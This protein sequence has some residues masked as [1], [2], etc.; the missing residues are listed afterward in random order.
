VIRVVTVAV[1]MLSGCT[2][3]F[4]IEEIP[5][6]SGSA[7]DGGLDGSGSVDAKTF[8]DGH[9][10]NVTLTV[11]VAPIPTQATAIDGRI[12][13][14]AP[15]I[16]CSLT[17]PQTQC[18]ATVPWGTQVDLLAQPSG[19]SDW[20]VWNGACAGQTPNIIP[21]PGQCHL[22]LTAD[23]TARS[24]FTTD[25]TLNLS[26]TATSALGPGAYVLVSSNFPVESYGQ[27]RCPV[28]SVCSFHF[29]NQ[30]FNV[31]LQAIDDNCAKWSMFVGAGCGTARSCNVGFTAGT[32]VMWVDYTYAPTGAVGCP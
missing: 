4:G 22:T 29:M 30:P 3:L 10:A 11:G 13:A 15:P 31:Q 27:D 21:N 28:G 32:L 26:P 24:A 16:D 25:Y 12:S 7:G 18:T 19:A 1:V 17:S 23:T 2:K 8:L 6:A 14:T 20:S 5:F 9:P